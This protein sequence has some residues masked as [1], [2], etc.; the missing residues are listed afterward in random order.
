MTLSR[1]THVSFRHNEMDLVA[2]ET[3]SAARLE[4]GDASAR[5][6]RDELAVDA[7]T[8]LRVVDADAREDCVGFVERS[9]FVCALGCNG[10]LGDQVLG[11]VCHGSSTEPHSSAHTYKRSPRQ[12]FRGRK[13]LICPTAKIGAS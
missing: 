7:H 10:P 13:N 3:I 4:F 9:D 8:A 1:W 11:A 6:S 5:I 2:E 12:L